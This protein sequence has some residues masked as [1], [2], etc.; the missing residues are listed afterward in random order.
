MNA[1]T[2]IMADRQPNRY[3]GELVLTNDGHRWV[4]RCRNCKAGVHVD[5]TPMRDKRGDT[6]VIGV[7]GLA[8]TTRVLNSTESVNLYHAC[9]RWVLLRRVRDGGKPDSKRHV[10]GARCTNATGP[11]C[12]CRCR[13]ANHGSGVG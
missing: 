13:G 11:M 2:I 4:G 6:L 10:C 8:Y 1:D 5:G 3:H 9:G 12:D 7:D